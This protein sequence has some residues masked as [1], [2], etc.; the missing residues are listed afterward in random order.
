MA[1]LRL[2]EWE[3]VVVQRTENQTNTQKSR[4]MSDYISSL[5]LIKLQEEEKRYI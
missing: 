4:Q 2:T 3:M 5:F 1:V